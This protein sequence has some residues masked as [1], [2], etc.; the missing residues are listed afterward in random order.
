MNVA[1]DRLHSHKDYTAV[2]VAGKRN[3]NSAPVA[4]LQWIAVG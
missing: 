1:C 3:D 4:V 2:S